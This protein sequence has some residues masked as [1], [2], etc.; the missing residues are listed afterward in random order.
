MDLTEDLYSKAKE[1]LCKVAKWDDEYRKAKPKVLFILK[2]P[3][4]RNN[5]PD[6]NFQRGLED[7]NWKQLRMWK[8]IAYCSEGLQALGR[9][10]EPRFQKKKPEE[11]K[12]LLRYSSYMNLKRFGAGTSS[13][14]GLVGLHAGLF[15][16]L[17]LSEIREIK[18]QI[19][20]CCATYS[21]LKE[22]LACLNKLPAY[23]KALGYPACG[24]LER[25]A[26][27]GRCVFWNCEAAGQKMA[28]INMAHP[29]RKNH[30]E[31]FDELMEL[32]S[33]VWCQIES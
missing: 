33:K 11:C 7:E 3:S 23:T 18:P 29:A 14:M 32:A 4:T 15:W 2:E 5:D 20:V 6:Y 25:D 21:I 31:Y 10:E 9:G 24:T 13:D 22:L 1:P 16:P 26:D 8:L 17:M 30:K 27:N 19:I 28:V 12:K